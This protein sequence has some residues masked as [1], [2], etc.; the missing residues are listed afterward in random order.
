[1]SSNLAVTDINFIKHLHQYLSLF[2]ITPWYDFDRNLLLRP[3]TQKVY[4]IMLLLISCLR[5]CY[6]ITQQNIHKVYERL[7]LSQKFTWYA[8]Y[9]AMSGTMVVALL[10]SCVYSTENWRKFFTNL[11]HIDASLPNYKKSERNFYIFF[12]T[13]QVVFVVITLVELYGWSAFL[14]MSFLE[15]LFTTCAI[16]SFYEFLIVLLLDGL[17]GCLKTRYKA[18]NAKLLKIPE[19][20]KFVQDLRSIVHDY[21]ILG[22]TVAMFNKIFGYQIVLIIFHFGLEMITS[23][24][25]TFVPPGFYT[26]EDMHFPLVL[27]ISLLLLW[28]LV[29]SNFVTIALLVQFL[30]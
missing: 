15:T 7:T 8:T 16:E 13:K 12:Y 1:M 29:S 23:L 26:S 24:S 3:K 21:R 5:M 18:L 9:V 10:K 14:Q 4:A 19:K 22:E 25:F 20:G 28:M 6:I 11:Q 30:F 17:L 2:L 27:A